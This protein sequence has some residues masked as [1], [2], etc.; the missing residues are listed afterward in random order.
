MK[1]V[2]IRVIA[3][4]VAIGLLAWLG[5]QMSFKEIKVPMPLQGEAAR[6]PFYAAI[7]LSEALGASAA[8]ERVFTQPQD[9]A[10]IFLSAW[11]WTLSKTRRERL[12]RWVEAGGRLIVDGSMVG[13][14]EE[15][16]RW[17]GVGEAEEEIADE[18]ESGADAEDDQEVTDR[19]GDFLARF[20]ER[21]CTRLV[22]DGSER[23]FKVCGI[24]HSRSLTSS[25]KL[26]W[27]LRDDHKIHALRTAVGRGSVTVINAVPFRFRGFLEGDHPTLFVRMA[28]L[29]R[30]DSIVFLSEGDH[31]SLLRLL[32]RFGA[33]ALL[34][35]AA[36]IALSLW[37]AGT[38]FGPPIPATMTAR[39]SLAEQIRGT[40]QF[41][42]RF[43][44]GRAL[45]EAALRAVRDAALQRFPNYDQM[46]SEAR[47]A[48]IARVSGLS[49]DELG[50]AMNYS[51]ARNSH[52]LYDAI[53]A[54]ESARRRLLS[55]K[56]AKHGN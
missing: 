52:E 6:N 50:P 25:R 8:W 41:A 5:S 55:S 48:A 45:H 1:G 27:A 28:Q 14:S 11:N 19:E 15:F 37:R 39:R 13:G 33:P 22:E 51:G 12:E 9:D 23:G 54:L 46:S 34:L 21:M 16:E 43:G 4:L 53:A 47:V 7:R 40:G 38:R 2:A 31:D 10:V 20:R 35:L 32:W 26:L 29:R 44:N 49:A 18:E 36:F 30:G 24:E 17:S 42:V 3:G 56:K